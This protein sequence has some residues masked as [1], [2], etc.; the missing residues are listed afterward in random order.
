[1]QVNEA[2]VRDTNAW[3]RWGKSV[4]AGAGYGQEF[5][6]VS[7]VNRWRRLRASRMGVWRWEQWVDRNIDSVGSS[8]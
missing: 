2:L 4:E 1:M 7:S 8:L 3:Q 6:G 5:G